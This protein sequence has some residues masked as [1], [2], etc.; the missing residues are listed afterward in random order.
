[1]LRYG[2]LR[3]A[4]H[5]AARRADPV[6]RNDE[7]A[8]SRATKQPDGQISKNLSSPPTKNIPLSPSGKSMVLIGPS[9]PTRGALRNVTKRAVGCGGR[10]G[11][12]DEGGLSVRRSRV[13]PTPRRWRQ[14]LRY[15]PR[16]DGGKKAVHQGGHVISRKTIAQ[17]RPGASA[18]P[19]RSCAAFAV[20][21]CTRDRGCGV[22]PVFP[23]PSVFRGREVSSKPRAISAARTR[24]H[25][26][27]ARCAVPR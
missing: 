21:I 2:L 22:H 14:V 7:V 13:V 8:L 16:G 25:G 5:P 27:F 19:V 12:E 17:G 15:D 20:R 6:A 10:E 9:R 4:C 3:G 1:M 26:R 11:H 24:T 23:A 18:E